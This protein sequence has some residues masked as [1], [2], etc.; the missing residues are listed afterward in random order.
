MKNV[1]IFIYSVILVLSLS[2]C[3]KWLDIN[4]D[5]DNPTTS[6]VTLV[7]PAAQASVA[8]TVSGANLFNLG[9]FFAQY[10]DQ[11][12]TANQYNLTSTYSLQTDDYNTVWTELYAGA[13]NDLKYVMEESE[14]SEEWGNYLAAVTL[15]AYTYQLLVDLHDKVPYKEALQGTAK[16]TPL[17][18]NGAVVYDSIISEINSAL[19]KPLAGKTVVSSDLYF[20]GNLND[21]IAFAKTLKLKIYL[22]MAYTT[23]PHST[24]I[25]AL[26]TEG[27]FITKN[28]GIAPTKYKNEQNKRNPWY[29]TNVS[30]LSGD[31]AYSINH[32]ASHNL[33][34][35]LLSKNDPRINSLFNLP[36]NGGTHFGNYFGSSK[37]T[38]EA[39]SNTQD[40]FSTIKI[41]YNH[42]SYIMSLPEAFLLQAEASA[43]A[44]NMVDAKAMYEAAITASLELNGLTVAGSTL[45]GPG[46]PYE[47][48]AAPTLA[49][50]L[51]AIMMQKWVCLAHSNNIEAWIEQSRTGIPEISD[52][53]GKDS[54]Y[55]VGEWTSPVDN[56]LGK[57]RF[58]HRLYYPEAEVSSNPNTP[59]QITDIASKVWWD[60]ND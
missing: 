30:R 47:F 21:W 2:S 17:Y 55:V 19:S 48:P 12:P 25:A 6:T 13:L 51:Q 18:D 50:A 42:P 58:P 43:R 20:E 16:V 45:F 23:N 60:L 41:P 57:G 40:D 38:A 7:L 44:A 27:N 35:Y 14:K 36:E 3:E 4:D 34:S 59:T 29:E 9:G 1:L 26:L 56:K 54:T 11:N 15:K 49:D 32:V 46:A 52:V 39:K 31:A 10:W 22:R 5:P 28:V 24:E 37:I 8:V 53:Y 33:V